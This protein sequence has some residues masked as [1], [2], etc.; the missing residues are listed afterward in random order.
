MSQA[1]LIVIFGPT[2][3]GKTALALALAEHLSAEILSCDS[4][5]VYRHMELGTAKPSS[6]ERARVPHPL[7]ALYD[8]DDPCT[9]GDYPRHARTV[10][11]DLAARNTLPII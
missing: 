1:S 5:A 8:P 2:A 9:A 7:L 11:A 4:V 3:S 6:P 10:L